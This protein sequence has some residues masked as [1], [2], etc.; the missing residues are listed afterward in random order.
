MNTITRETTLADLAVTRAGASRVFYK[1][2]LDFC[3]HGNVSLKETCDRKGIKFEMLVDEIE[4]QE[5]VVDETFDRW[6]E[7][8][9]DELIAYIFARFHESHRRDIPRL[10]DMAK[11]VEKIHRTKSGCPH[12]LSDCLEQMYAELERHMQKEETILFPIICSGRG[13]LAIMP[14]HV[15]EREHEEAGENLTRLRRLTHD[16]LTPD[17]A[18]PTWRALYFGLAEFEEELM[19]HIH[20]ENNVLF[21]RALRPESV[22][23]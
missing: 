16:F 14:I 7:K 13:A 23:S 20:L 5:Q 4:Q 11:K 17:E 19:Q 18:C 2:G 3:C 10:I 22:S 15:M 21:L 8:P 6:D 12:G 1:Y 9:L